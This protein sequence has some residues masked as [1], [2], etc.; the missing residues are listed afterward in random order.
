[1]T[2]TLK[3][4]RFPHRAVS[5]V[6]LVL[7]LAAGLVLTPA[8]QA[9]S[10]AAAA[11][12][13]SPIAYR[14]SGQ[15]GS[16]S[17]LGWASGIQDSTGVITATLTLADPATLAPVSENLNG[18]ISGKG[19]AATVLLAVTPM[20]GGK[21]SA[22]SMAG[23][24][25]GTAGQWAGTITKGSAYAGLWT[26]ASQ[27]ATINLNFGGKSATTSKDKVSVS[28]LVSVGV[29][30]NGWADG[31]YSSFDG[32]VRTVVHGWVNQGGDVEFA[33]P[34][35]KGGKAGTVVLVGLQG[36]QR[37]THPSWSGTFIGPGVGDSGT[38]IA[39]T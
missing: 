17:L 5:G 12:T 32:S 16:T 35:G 24:A 6:L 36:K 30:A 23:G 9:S 26:L 10:R 8:T 7:A 27:T 3:Q 19:A 20:K 38:W 18:T 33:I 14:L 15:M 21:G 1:M 25:T 2:R 37:L 11:V 22:W 31:T 34:W 4:R 13:T 28:G 39:Q 29:T